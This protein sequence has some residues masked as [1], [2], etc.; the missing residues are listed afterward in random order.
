MPAECP[1]FLPAAAGG[2]GGLLA[3]VLL[4]CLCFC[5]C[6]ERLAKYR[7]D[8]RYGIADGDTQLRKQMPAMRRF[9][10]LNTAAPL[11]LLGLTVLVVAAAQAHAI[12]RRDDDDGTRACSFF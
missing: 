11:V 7:F 5:C 6:R 9:N 3:I 10:A 12:A 1:W 4:L 8:F 2:G